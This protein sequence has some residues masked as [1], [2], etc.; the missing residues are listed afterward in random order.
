MTTEDIEIPVDEET[1]VSGLLL[2]PEDARFL[3]VL[4]HGAGAGMEHPFME[5]I[6]RRL[7]VRGVASL[8]YQFPYMEA[9]R[10]RP[11][12]QPR[13]EATVRAAVAAAAA[14]GLA[15]I[16][17][18]KSM[19]GRMTSNAQATRPLPGVRGIAFLGFPLHQP[20]QGDTGRSVHLDAVG[21]PMLFVQGT[22]DRL[23]DLDRIEP[24]VRRL[25]DRATLHVVDGGDHSFNVLKR[26]GR[27]QEEVM[28]E[29]ADAVTEWGDRILE[30][31]VAPTR[32]RAP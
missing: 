20:G 26:S 3:Y 1:I 16:A 18:G 15:L 32:P 10:K 5:E 9:G 25:G 29:V 30:E 6:A 11:D 28:A 27:A 24:V 2:R 13:L 23:A 8:R 21:L 22:R 14:S 31:E 19:G 7:V 17:G 12:R 4:A